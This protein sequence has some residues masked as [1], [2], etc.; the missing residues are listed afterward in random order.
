MVG[1]GSL[2]VEVLHSN[3]TLWMLTPH[4]LFPFPLGSLTF[5]VLAPP[6]WVFLVM[7]LHIR[8]KECANLVVRDGGTAGA[9]AGNFLAGAAVRHA[10]MEFDVGVFVRRDIHMPHRELLVA[11][12]LVAVVILR[13]V[14]GDAS[15][16]IGH[17][18]RDPHCIPS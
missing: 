12:D 7:T 8:W 9:T 17:L 11:G 3:L 1:T 13:G 4:L 18:V 15:A 5:T 6:H 10:V 2:V 14:G 16:L